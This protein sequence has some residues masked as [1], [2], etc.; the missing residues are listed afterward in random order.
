LQG[1][2]EGNGLTWFGNRVEGY[3]NFLWVTW[4]ALG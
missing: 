2:V 4:I 3:T 1:L